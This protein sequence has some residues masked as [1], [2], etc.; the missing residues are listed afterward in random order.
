VRQSQPVG[1]HLEPAKEQEVN[2]DG[3]R[4]M[5]RAVEVATRLS[6][7]LLAEIKQLLR[8]QRCPDPDSC[9]E[10]VR[11]GE[12]LPHRLGFVKRGDCFD[13]D[14]FPA[15]ALDRPAKL[16]LAITDVRPE[17]EIPNST[18][19]ALSRALACIQTPS[20][21]SASRSSDFSRVTS[22]PASWTT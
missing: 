13:D 4:A 2:V 18:R 20:S 6:L 8:L 12:D 7:D 5:T 21:S 9:V 15:K 3:P 14:T 19:V 1:D 16:R 11:L 10:E 22:T 17:T